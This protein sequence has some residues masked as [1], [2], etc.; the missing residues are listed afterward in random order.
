MG[1]K[2]NLKGKEII[3]FKKYFKNPTANNYKKDIGRSVG[4]RNSK[5]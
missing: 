1:I 3:L 4:P 2:N 5:F